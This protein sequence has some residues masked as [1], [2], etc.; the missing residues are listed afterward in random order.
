M[1]TV[2]SALYLDFD[3]VFSGLIK[4]DPRLALRFAEDPAGWLSRL[5]TE[6]LSDGTRRWLVLRCYMNPSG[7]I[8]HPE[9]GRR[10]TFSR[11]RLPFT[12][13]GFEVVD[14][15]R[16]THTKNGAD[17]KLVLD[18]AED[19]RADVRYGEFVIASGDSDMTPLLVRLRAADRRV[20]VISPSASAVVLGAIADRLIGGDELLELLQAESMELSEDLDRPDLGAAS[21]DGTG[22]E[23]APSPSENPLDS[24]QAL[25]RFE[26]L[27]RERYA[28]AT[29]PLNLAALG[30][31]V[32][33]EV[34]A[35]AT[36]SRW[37][38]HGGFTRALQSLD[39]PRA[40]MSSHYLWDSSR[41]E[42]PDESEPAA[43]PS[44]TPDAV[45]R[46]T[47][48]LRLPRLRHEA[49]GLIFES[50]AA[51]VSAYDFNLTEA[52][53]WARDRLVER[54]V[55]VNRKAVSVVAQGA[56]YGGCPLYR[57]PAP[58]ADEIGEAF[59]DNVLSRA[60]A[61]DLE[62]TEPD[63]EAVR[64]WFGGSPR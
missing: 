18:A 53:R 30:S 32:R 63:I 37:F 8:V 40:R 50:L 52:T 16:L 14:C 35:V 31:Q 44:S 20:T 59:V 23:A 29:A 48:T 36:T 54:G 60:L 11:F 7:S 5:T 49:W 21:L 55:E 58:A 6:L 15:P 56:S 2:G 64:T 9:D 33:G 62:M 22:L 47:A 27:V 4:L 17:I 24:H 42:P 12:D 25:S 3:N 26:A 46:V 10:I 38:G 45:A 61:A 57:K 19:V 34:G 51:F 43:F 39:L 13:A 1:R 28:S 41:H